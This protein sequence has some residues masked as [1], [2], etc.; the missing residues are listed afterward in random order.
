MK[1]RKVCFGGGEKTEKMYFPEFNAAFGVD[2]H[3]YEVSEVAGECY[4]RRIPPHR[5][6]HKDVELYRLKNGNTAN[7]F[8]VRKEVKTNTG[9]IQPREL[10]YNG[11]GLG[12]QYAQ[13]C[14]DVVLIFSRNVDSI[15]SR[16][17]LV[18][19]IYHPEKMS[20]F[21][22]P[23]GNAWVSKSKISTRGGVLTLQSWN[24]RF[25][26]DE[27]EDSYRIDQISDQEA[28]AIRAATPYDGEAED[29]KPAEFISE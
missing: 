18:L 20:V 5:K 12:S 14:G 13:A 29:W 27:A 10:L 6:S 28:A 8:V 21:T 22:I 15:L 16:N 23:V 19:P 25:V 1:N 17:I 4:A 2:L 26:H 3:L 11:Y 24:Y 9:I 7:V